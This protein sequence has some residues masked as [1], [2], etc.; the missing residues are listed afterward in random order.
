ME[1]P[2]SDQDASERKEKKVR[3]PWIDPE[4]W[5]DWHF[6]WTIFAVSWCVIMLVVYIVFE[7]L[8]VLSLRQ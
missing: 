2:M 3:K 6:W 7:T 4:D 8:R 1:F 5:Y